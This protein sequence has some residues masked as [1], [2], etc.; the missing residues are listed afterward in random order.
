M[1]KFKISRN[2]EIGQKLA[3]IQKNFQNV[4]NY[5]N[6][7]GYNLL[8][9]ENAELIGFWIHRTKL[10][11]SNFKSDNLLKMFDVKENKDLIQLYFS[12]SFYGQNEMLKMQAIG[13]FYLWLFPEKMNAFS[14]S[15][16]HIS[17]CDEFVYV[18]SNY[19]LENIDG[20]GFEAA[21]L[22]VPSSQKIFSTDQFKQVNFNLN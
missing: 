19:D 15:I 16:M 1:K 18:R 9:N 22:L 11:Q 4:L 3:K 2:S 17:M 8:L 7:K 5:A 13:K 20:F 21:E 12:N 6:S 14:I 10:A